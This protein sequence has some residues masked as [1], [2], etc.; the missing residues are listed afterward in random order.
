MKLLLLSFFVNLLFTFLSCDLEQGWK[1]IKVFE[2]TR[3]DVE[4]KLG[5]PIK[6]EDGE[7]RY[8]TEE[9][10]FR[11]LF[12]DGPCISP[13]TLLGGFD[14]KAGVVLQY[15]VQPKNSL[16]VDDLEWEK[17]L[18]GRAE[19]THQLGYVNYY[20]RRDAIRIV[21]QKTPLEGPEV[22]REIY[23]ERTLDQVAKFGCNAK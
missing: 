20:N 1:G 7:V 19:D 14:V 6:D 2:S 3:A 12:S 23:F 16:R 11:F 21:A 22:V 4:K 9:A 18:Y 13:Q 10:R 5:K 8:E 17:N 15:E